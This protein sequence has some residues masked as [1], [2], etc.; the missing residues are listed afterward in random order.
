MPSAATAQESAHA[1]EA[2]KAGLVYALGAYLFWGVVPIFW[3]QL[4]G[5]AS[6]EVLAHRIVWAFILLF[7]FLAFKGKIKETVELLKDPKLRNR[8]LLS[9]LCIGLNWPTYVWAVNNGYIVEGSLGYFINPLVLMLLG[10]VFLG[11][12]L[13]S[14]QWLAVA[15]ATAGIVYLTVGYGKFPWISIVLAVTFGFY[16]L[17]RKTTPISASQGLLTE[18]AFMGPLV[19]AYF[20]Y[21]YGTGT[22]AAGQDLKTDALLIAAGAVTVIP[23]LLFAKGARLLPLTIIGFCQYL[24]P[25]MQ[26]IIGVRY[27][28][29]PFT[30]SHLIAFS[31]IW[32]GIAVFLG[33]SLLRRKPREKPA[34]T[35]KKFV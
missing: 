20:A 11:E 19:M 35:G 32:L 3:K 17:I 25:S 16:G 2:H 5:V 7:L 30:T 26:L 24:S 34:V 27:Y 22:M 23:L 33:D 15:L 12:Q 10:R 31:L 29:E 21:L 4:Q 13:R 28:D 9:T 1:Q 14:W 6:G 8:M 18:T